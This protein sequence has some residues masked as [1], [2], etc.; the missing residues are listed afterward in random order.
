MK[1]GVRNNGKIISIM[2]DWN[3][4]GG[5]GITGVY[6]VASNCAF[7]L[8]CHDETVGITNTI[9]DDFR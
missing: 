4:I 6:L 9:R 2:E 1:F 7:E 8:S 5:D 3:K